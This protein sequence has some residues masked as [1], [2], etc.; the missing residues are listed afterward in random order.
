LHVGNVLYLLALT[1]GFQG[2]VQVSKWLLAPCPG[3]P[4]EVQVYIIQ[5]QRAKDLLT[6]KGE[7]YNYETS[8]LQSKF[9]YYGL[10]SW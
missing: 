7:E 8:Y 10:A 1:E 9:K 3:N 4:P 6:N 2:R 5:I